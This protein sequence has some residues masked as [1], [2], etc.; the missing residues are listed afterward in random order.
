MHTTR[1]TVREFVQLCGLPV[2]ASFHCG[3]P[4]CYTAIERSFEVTTIAGN[5]RAEEPNDETALA[6]AA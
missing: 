5:V 2:T 6:E 1:R 3:H 4:E